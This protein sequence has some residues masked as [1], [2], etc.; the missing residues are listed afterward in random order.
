MAFTTR[1]FQF[2]LQHSPACLDCKG[3]FFCN[4]MVVD[5]LCNTS[6]PVATHLRFTAIVVEHAHAGIR[7]IGRADK[8]EPIA[9]HTKIAI[10]DF[11]C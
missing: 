1:C 6:Y 11:R 2:Q 5:K 3:G 4:A 7:F 9:A 8:N 10:A